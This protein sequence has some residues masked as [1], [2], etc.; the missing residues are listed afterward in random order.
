MITLICKDVHF[1]K[2]VMKLRGMKAHLMMCVHVST[3]CVCPL[4]GGSLLRILSHIIVFSNLSKWTVYVKEKCS[5]GWAGWYMR[6]QKLRWYQPER[7]RCVGH[8]L[9]TLRA[10][11]SFHDARMG[12]A[13]WPVCTKLLKEKRTELYICWWK[14]MLFLQHL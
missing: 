12:Q 3:R 9:Q 4:Y 6:P 11:S 1:W 13:W 5:L 14:L 8:A 10:M 7:W 2:N